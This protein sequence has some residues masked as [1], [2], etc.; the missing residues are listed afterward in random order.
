MTAMIAAA[1]ADGEVDQTESSRI[2]GQMEQ[3]GLT[4]EEKSFVLA[5][6]SK[7][8]DLDDVAKLATTPEIAAQ[9]YTASAIVIDQA[10]DRERDYLT[11]LA[12]RMNLDKAFVEELNKQT[13]GQ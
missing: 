2:F 10:S 5:E 8:L 4:S 13:S 12:E 1:K 9:L 11:K 3:S 7:P 6:L